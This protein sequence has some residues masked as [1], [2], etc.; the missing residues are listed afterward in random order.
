MTIAGPSPKAKVNM[1]RPSAWYQYQRGLTY[2][3]GKVSQWSDQTANA[4]HL[5]QATDSARPLQ[6]TDGS[7]LCDGSATFLQTATFTLVQPT[8]VYALFRQVTFSN[9]AV[10][11]D[12]FTVTSGQWLQ[13]TS[14]PNI[15]MSAGTT[16]GTN[17]SFVLNTYC[18]GVAVFSGANSTLNRNKAVLPA[19]ANAGTTAM[20][21]LTV[22]AN[23]SGASF[24]NGQFKEIIV[25]PVAH[26]PTQQLQVTNYLSTVGGLGL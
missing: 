22:G 6:Q 21:G 17:T 5:L 13:D 7:I 15:S 25:F 14:T 4:R 8:T 20:A 19:V 1:L 3:S 9:G 18:V 24:A 12:G 2:S 26:T 10:L 16:A 23:G 11:I